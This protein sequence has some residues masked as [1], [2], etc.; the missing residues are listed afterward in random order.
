MDTLKDFYERRERWQNSATVTE[1][2]V[3]EGELRL[4]LPTGAKMSFQARLLRPLAQ[5]S[6]E[7]IAKV[8]VDAGGRALFWHDG[9]ASINVEAL[10]EAVT[11]LQS[12]RMNA[13]KGGRAKSEAKTAAVRANGAKGGRPRKAAATEQP[14]NAE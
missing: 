10:L 6:D 12:H 4:T 1:A 8:R 3:E 14:E 5:L 11:G 9:G 7:Q 2:S 13:A